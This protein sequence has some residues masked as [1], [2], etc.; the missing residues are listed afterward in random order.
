[1]ASEQETLTLET[2]DHAQMK[3]YR[4]LITGLKDKAAHHGPPISGLKQT[5][6]NQIILF[7]AGSDVISSLTWMNA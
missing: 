1:M 7:L 2:V 3:R 4:L 5:L 6:L